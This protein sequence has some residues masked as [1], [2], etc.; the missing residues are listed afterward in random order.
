MAADVVEGAKDAIPPSNDQDRLARD[1]GDDEV[2]R[3]F[4]L[5]FAS[6]LLPGPSEDPV[7]VEPMMVGIE[8]P[9]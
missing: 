2:T 7:E 9:R 8:I 4:D 3:L 1:V 5:L 6:D